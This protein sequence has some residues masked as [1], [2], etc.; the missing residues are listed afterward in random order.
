MNGTAKMVIKNI[1][2][3]H[4]PQQNK[5]FHE[6]NNNVGCS[7][8]VFQSAEGYPD[9]AAFTTK[10]FNLKLFFMLIFTCHFW[11]LDKH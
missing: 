1:S 10:H 2:S 4:M 5:A 11:L 6:P 3:G 9:S 7:N 8:S